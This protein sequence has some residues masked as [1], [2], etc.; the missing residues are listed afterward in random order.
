M[1]KRP[2]VGILSTGDE[3][4]EPGQPL[5]AGQVYDSNRTTIIA[6]VKEQ[7]FESL[8]LGIARDE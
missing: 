3:V 5:V 7:G 4:V 1:S 2:R 6:A 8:D